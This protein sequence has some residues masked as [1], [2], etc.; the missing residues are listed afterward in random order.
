[1]LYLS[2]LAEDSSFA[3]QYT[4]ALAALDTWSGQ[5]VSVQDPSTPNYPNAASA[6]TALGQAKAAAAEWPNTVAPEARAL[7][8]QIVNWNPQI[9]AA[10]AELQQLAAQPQ[11]FSSTVRSAISQTAGTAIGILSQTSGKVA[12][13]TRDVGTL[14]ADVASAQAAFLL[15]QH[16]AL[17]TAAAANAQAA[18]LSAQL[19]KEKSAAS[20]NADHIHNTSSALA[21]AQAEA[22]DAT[23]WAQLAATESAELVQA[24]P[25]IQFLSSYWAQFASELAHVMTELR[26]V[27]QDADAVVGID[28]QAALDGWDAVYADMSALASLLA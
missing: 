5:I 1:M 15:V 10:I 23:T 8:T 9:G 6:A 16:D 17:G 13:F 28:V 27:T 20:P 12:T 21:S 26:S 22:A 2:L 7:P 4:A 14:A 11:P 24:N 25:S 18:S 19:Q 3:S